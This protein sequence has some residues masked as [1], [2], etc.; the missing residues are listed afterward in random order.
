[1]IKALIFDFGK[2]LVDYDFAHIID[3]LF[4]KEEDKREFYTFFASLEFI[5][6]LDREVTPF[7]DIIRR[8]Q[9][10]YPKYTEQLQVFFDKYVDFVT[11]EVPGMKLLLKELKASG[12]ELYGLTN[13]SSKV[14]QVMKNYDIFNMLDGQVISSEVH[15]L[16]PEPEIYEHLLEKFGLQAEECVFTDDKAINVEGAEK[17]GMHGI[18][19]HDAA[20]YVHELTAIIEQSA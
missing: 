20:Q 13:W 18:V 1:M 16:K 5:N 8:K 17:V 6:E 11:G 15:L 14:H 7:I 3:P 19:F 9:Q 4:D 10:E 12:Y 2:V